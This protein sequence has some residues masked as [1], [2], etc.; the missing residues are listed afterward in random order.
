VRLPAM[1]DG[2]SVVVKNLTFCSNTLLL[3]TR[4]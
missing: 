3:M 2:K 4:S 1:G